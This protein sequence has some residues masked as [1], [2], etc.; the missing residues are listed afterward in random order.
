MLAVRLNS[1][2][3]LPLLVGFIAGVLGLAGRAQAELKVDVTRGRS[4]RYRLRSRISL[5]MV[6]Q[7]SSWGGEFLALFKRISR[8]LASLIPSMKRPLLMLS[9]LWRRCLGSRTG[10]FSMPR[11]WSRAGLRFSLING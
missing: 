3:F 8:A 5:G 11:P 9:A 6:P 1:K 7:K 4:S 10:A 2:I